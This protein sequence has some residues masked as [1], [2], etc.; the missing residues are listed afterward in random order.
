MKRGGMLRSTLAAVVTVTMG[1]IWCAAAGAQT[2]ARISG[3]LMD[4]QGKPYPSVTV[5]ITNTANNQSK[6]ITTDKE[7]KF[8][9][10]GLSG[11][12]YALNFKDAA[13]NP[14]LDY[15]IKAF[16]VAAEQ[17]N[18]LT[19]NLKDQ[20][21][22]Y[23][24]EHPAEE[25]AKSP[26]VSQFQSMKQGFQAGLDAM[27][28]ASAE[29][30]SPDKKK[31]DCQMAATAFASAAQA[32]GPKDTKNPP[33]ILAHEGEALECEGKYSDAVDAYQKAIAIEPNAGFYVSLATEISLAAAMQPGVADAQLDDALAK[34]GAACAQA[35]ALDPTKAGV[36]WRNVGIPFYNKAQMKQASNALQKA[37]AADPS[38]PDQW[39]YLGT[40]L[41]NL[42]G[43]KQEKDKIIYI[44]Q[45]GTAEAFQKYIDLAPTGPNAASAKEDLATIAT[46]EGGEST[47]LKNKKK[48]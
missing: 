7:G 9:Q 20:A 22:A 19:V 10:L 27:Q 13:A 16:P 17:D 36:C 3:Q 25:K 11:G 2:N 29:K 45:P 42:M 47:V 4:L 48:K 43:S 12:T 21:D 28:A 40:A 30:G 35:I 44:V 31:A 32:A 26:D 39:Y 38:N 41:L 46:L 37:T 6:T 15:T 34:A 8:V 14:P 23:S 18:P 33:L 5:T 24:K 1:L